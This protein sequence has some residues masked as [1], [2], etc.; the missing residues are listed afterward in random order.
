[1]NI[2]ELLSHL[3]SFES[4]CGFIE[5]Y[6]TDEI[7]KL[8][9]DALSISAQE[10]ANSAMGG[11][12]RLSDN[13]GSFVKGSGCYLFVLSDLKQNFSYYKQ[14]YSRLCDDISREVFMNQLRFRI[15]PYTNYLKAAYDLS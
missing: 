13:E 10:L 14:F 12:S 1:M 9:S 6:E 4:V 11:Y 5:Q 8:V 3:E 15:L 2:Q 7:L